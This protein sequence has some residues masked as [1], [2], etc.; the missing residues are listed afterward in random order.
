MLQDK[1]ASEC[2]NDAIALMGL[3][4]LMRQAMKLIRGVQIQQDD[5]TFTF[6]VFSLISWF[7]VWLR[8]WVP[9]PAGMGFFVPE[10]AASS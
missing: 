5:S 7:K 10:A 6:A 1:E 4:A 9:V 3:S 2:M 8:I